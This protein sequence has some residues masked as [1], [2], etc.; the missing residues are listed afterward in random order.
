M[1]YFVLAYGVFS[2]LLVFFVTPWLIKYLRRIS[3]VVKDQNKKD[4]PLVPISGGL[5]VLFGVC[6]GLLLFVFYRTFFVGLDGGGLRPNYQNLMLLF[7]SMV[8]LFIITLVGFLDDLVIK[9]SK[10]YSLGLRQWQKPLLTLVAAVPLMVVR[11]GSTQMLLPIIG[12]I[13]LGILYPLLIIPIGVVGA[14][15]M[16]N[17]LAGYN[18][19]ESGMGVVYIGM[20]GVYAYFN[21]RSV[22]ALFAMVVFF[23]LLAFYLYNKYPA[24]ILPGDSLTYL[25]GAAIAIIA[26]IGNIEKAAII[27]GI[28]FYVEFILKVRSKFK[29]QSY[30]YYHKGKVKVDYEKIYSLPHLFARTGRYTEKQIVYFMILIQIVFSSLIWLI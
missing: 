26:I 12:W 29:A 10:D 28:P 21:N 24:K 4:K 7:A 19:M 9:K 30:G 25:L 8:S 11:A 5:A 22:A 27:G 13:D 18:G 2:F 6:G 14:S 15:N 17:M 16:V 3:L 23:A 1:G 20:L